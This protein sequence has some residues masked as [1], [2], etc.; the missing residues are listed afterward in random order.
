MTTTVDHRHLLMILPAVQ[1]GQAPRPTPVKR[2]APPSKPERPSKPPVPPPLVQ[3]IRNVSTQVGSPADTKCDV[4]PWPPRENVFGLIGQETA[5]AK[6]HNKAELA[7]GTGRRF[8]D[9]LFI[10]SAGVGKSSLARSVAKQ[11]LAEDP[12]F[13]SGS[14]L[15]QPSALIEKLREQGKV[16]GRARGRVRVGKCLVFIDEVHALAKSTATALLSAMDDA[17]VATVGGVEYYFGDVI[18]IAATTDKGLLSDPFVSRMDI[19]PLAAYSLDELAGIIW[20]HGRKLFGG[21]ELP[22]EVC[23]EV[24]AR[25]RCNPRRAVRGLENDLLAEF[26]NKLPPAERTAKNAEP[27]AAALMTVEAVAAYYDGHG[28]DLNGLDDLGRKTLAYLKTHGPSPEDRMS[29]G[30]RISN[31]SDFVELIEYLTR[32]GLVSTSHQGRQLTGDGRR[33]LPAAI[34][35][36]ERI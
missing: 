27:A 18:F 26:Y 1:A 25:S 9:T 30:L 5:A 12:V 3:V 6:L 24:A 4:S 2:P 29:R 10:G 16:P 19:I 13:F 11:L 15:P 35:L 20:H 17:R 34:N 33:Y 23:L 36:R 28:V 8:T 14:D 22:R 21:F 32:L 31:R 7:R